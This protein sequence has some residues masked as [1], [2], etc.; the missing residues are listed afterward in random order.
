MARLCASLM[1]M[2]LVAQAVEYGSLEHRQMHDTWHYAPTSSCFGNETAKCGPSMW[3][4]VA[5]Y[6][7]CAEQG[8]QSPTDLPFGFPTRATPGM[9]LPDPLVLR[10]PEACD[11][12]KFILNEHTSEVAFEETCGDSSYL[13]FVTS[14]TDKTMK[15]WLL[16]QFHYHSPSEH[17]VDGKYFPMEVHHVHHS[18]DGDQALVVSVMIAVGTPTGEDVERAQ[19]LLDMQNLMPRPGGDAAPSPGGNKYEWFKEYPGLGAAYAKFIDVSEGY[20]YY[21][22][23]FTTPPCTSHTNWVIAKRPVVVPQST[24][25]LYRELINSNTYNQL[26]PFEAITGHPLVKHA[27]S[28]AFEYDLSLGSNNRPIQPFQGADNPT[29]ALYEVS[30]TELACADLK[31]KYRQEQCCDNP[32]KRVRL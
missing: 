32:A 4:T 15:K 13:E 6:E 28:G 29:R 27:M 11:G 2:Q 19:F 18:E 25:D 31:H 14:P 7:A 12:A 21:E 24:L 3:S 26:A 22:G 1:G 23:S 8:T 20:F 9:G 30:H 16:S 17:T 10:H 5:G